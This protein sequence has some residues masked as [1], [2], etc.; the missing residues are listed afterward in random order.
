MLNDSITLYHSK[1][2]DEV[3]SNNYDSYV[4]WQSGSS[5]CPFIVSVEPTSWG[6]VKS[7]YR[8]P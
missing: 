7:K 4:R 6:V 5:D 1:G 3:Y 8:E 2:K